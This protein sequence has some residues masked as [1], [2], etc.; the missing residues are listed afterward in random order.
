MEKAAAAA[1]IAEQAAK[2]KKDLEKAK[3]AYDLL[4][5]AMKVRELI[6]QTQTKTIQGVDMTSLDQMVKN[7]FSIKS[8]KPSGVLSSSAIEGPM[9]VLNSIVAVLCDVD[10]ESKYLI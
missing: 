4:D 7:S 5:A 8:Q 1:K 10:L 2:A 3:H 6:K 9:K